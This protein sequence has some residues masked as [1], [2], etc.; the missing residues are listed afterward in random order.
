MALSRLMGLR[1]CSHLAS[2]AAKRSAVLQLVHRLKS[3]GHH[4]S[5][6]CR[7]AQ[8]RSKDSWRCLGFESCF[9]RLNIVRHTED[10]TGKRA[11]K[12]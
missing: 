3:G 11:P 8:N 5:G 9:Y 10:C 6:F 12:I 7:L 2:K 1:P 4:V